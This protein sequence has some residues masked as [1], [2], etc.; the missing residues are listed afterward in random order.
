M[1]GSIIRIIPVEVHIQ[2]VG[3]LNT[4]YPTSNLRKEKSTGG[5]FVARMLAYKQQALFPTSST[6][7]AAKP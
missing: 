2:D 5:N 4:I 6:G 7:A 1:E 3:F